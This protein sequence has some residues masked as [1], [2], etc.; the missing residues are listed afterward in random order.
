MIKADLSYNPYISE[1]KV[2][3]NGHPPRINSMIEKY[4]RRPL[5][6]W[7]AEIPQIFHDEMNGYGFQLDFYGTELDFDEVK[8]AFLKAVVSEREVQISLKNELECREVKIEKLRVL[9]E[10]LSEYRY[11]NFAYDKFKADNHDILEADFVGIVLHGNSVK[12]NLRGVSVENVD[13]IKELECT[14]LTH[15]PILYCITRENTAT[16]HKDINYLRKR[17]DTADDQL[18]FCVSKDENI[19]NIKRLLNDIGIAGPVIVRDINDDLV[20]K[21]FLIYPFTDHINSAIECFRNA[22][23]NVSEIINKDNEKSKLNGDRTHDLLAEINEKADK[24][25]NCDSAVIN[26]DKPEYLHEYDE[27]V[28]D[29]IDK[30]SNW[31]SRKTKITDPVAAKKAVTEF[32]V[33]VN[34]FYS[35]FAQ[36]LNSL[37]ADR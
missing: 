34:K 14:D 18:F 29:F 6:D 31:E 27:L 32:V 24:I 17:K 5:Q 2:Q 26:S 36:Q 12:P 9:H 10:W 13:S 37:M 3:F 19:G 16:L 15:T 11:R 4:Q 20:R 1:L 7:I 23:E 30:I 25:R 28:S 21:Y 33:A 8:N 35:E 22:I